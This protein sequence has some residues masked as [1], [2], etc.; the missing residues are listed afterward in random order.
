M[1]DLFESEEQELYGALSRLPKFTGQRKLD[2]FI[3]RAK[4]ARAV[5]FLLSHLRSKMPMLMF[6]EAAKQ[7]LLENLENEYRE[8]AR[9]KNLVLGDFPNPNVMRNKL[10][11]FDFSILPKLNQQKMNALEEMLSKRIPELADLLADETSNATSANLYQLGGTSGP[12]L[13]GAKSVSE[14]WFVPMNEGEHAT[15][16]NALGGGTTGKITSAQAKCKL[17]ESKLQQR[18][19]HKIWTLADVDQD[20]ALTL[21]EYALAMHFVKMKL[22]GLDLPP[23]LPPQMLPESTPAWAS[24][25]A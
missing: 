13:F 11:S 21:Y 22:A 15:E 10:A 1:R 20:G 2:D 24:A 9:E 14:K 4:L 5:A 25:G 16:F 12:A 17:I 8:I 7:K 6:K 23:S 18:V 19:L 3:K